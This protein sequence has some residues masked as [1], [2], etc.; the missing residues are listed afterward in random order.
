MVSLGLTEASAR[1]RT[2]FGEA[3]VTWRRHNS[4]SKAAALEVEV[5]IPPFAVAEVQVP[6]LLTDADLDSLGAGA[7]SAVA[8][9][10]VGGCVVHCASDLSTSITSSSG[11]T[12]EASPDCTA[13]DAVA[14]RASCHARLDG[15]LV[16]SFEAVTTGMHTFFMQH[17]PV[18]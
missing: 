16:M 10:T 11:A 4:S 18:N 3:A 14:K 6:L 7:D 1:R 13:D 15:E 12:E 2:P 17:Q 5:R 9:V 8:T